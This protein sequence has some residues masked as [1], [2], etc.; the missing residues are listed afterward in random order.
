MES[1]SNLVEG[2][3]GHTKAGGSDWVVGEGL[4]DHDLKFRSQRGKIRT[5]Y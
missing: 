1:L 5:A 2:L 3:A 4:K